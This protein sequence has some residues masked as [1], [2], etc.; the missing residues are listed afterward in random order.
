MSFYDS[1][2]KGFYYRAL[3]IGAALPEDKKEFIF[4]VFLECQLYSLLL[5]SKFLTQGE[6]RGERTRADTQYQ[7]TVW[8]NI[9][10]ENSKIKS[11]FKCKKCLKTKKRRKK[12][13]KKELR[14]SLIA[15]TGFTWT[16]NHA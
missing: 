10:I 12:E 16:T 14:E 11:D 13:K 1:R 8:S 3:F 6:R 4:W 7:A 5:L 15:V 9:K 2:I